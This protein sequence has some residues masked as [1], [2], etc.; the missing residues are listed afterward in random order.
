[1]NAR[2][3]NEI[4]NTGF[5]VNRYR[6]VHQYGSTKFSSSNSLQ[7]YVERGTAVTRP[8]VILCDLWPLF[9]YLHYV[10]AL[11]SGATITDKNDHT[12][13]THYLTKLSRKI[14][15]KA[16]AGKIYLS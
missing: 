16:L 4:N 9:R 10:P 8:R 2:D 3:E 5:G 15:V 12:A 6:C 14:M 7:L 1:V 11:A 13:F